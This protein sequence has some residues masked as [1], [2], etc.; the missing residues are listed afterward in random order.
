MDTLP[1]EQIEQRLT[2]LDG[3]SF[4]DDAITKT[5]EFDEFMDAVG[6]IN[7]VAAKADA[8]NHHPDLHNSYTTV[9]V[10]LTTHSAGGVTTKDLDLAREIEELE[11]I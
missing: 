8:A 1:S 5:F 7:A 6:F 9:N 4:E 2:D 11:A 10:T 3:W